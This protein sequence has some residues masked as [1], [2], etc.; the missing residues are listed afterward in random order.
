MGSQNMLPVSLLFNLVDRRVH[1]GVIGQQREHLLREQDITFE[2][3]VT[4]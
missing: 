2:K 3:E 1:E 4:Q